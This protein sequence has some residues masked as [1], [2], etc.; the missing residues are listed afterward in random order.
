MIVPRTCT[1]ISEKN[2]EQRQ[3]VVFR[4]LEEFDLFRPMSCSA[5]RRRK[6]DYIRDGV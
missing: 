1:E 6:V 3:G 5:I 2:D 4:P